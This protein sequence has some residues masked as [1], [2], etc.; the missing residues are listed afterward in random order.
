MIICFSSSYLVIYIQ[1]CTI[2]HLFRGYKFCEWT[3]KESFRKQFSRIYI[4]LQSAIL[5]TIGFPLIFDETN[6]VEAWKS[7]KFVALIKK[8]PSGNVIHNVLQILYLYQCNLH[9]CPPHIF[10]WIFLIHINNVH[11]I[12]FIFC[13]LHENNQIT[14]YYWTTVIFI[15]CNKSFNKMIIIIIV[16]YIQNIVT[17]KV[18][19]WY[20]HTAQYYWVIKYK[21]Y[22]VANMIV[23]A[24]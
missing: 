23:C 10:H 11:I 12:I 3:K 24:I 20:G 5:V 21:L 8:M 18:N 6:F 15:L 22:S 4:S 14:C 9:T 16:S 13:R 17:A 1:L 7:T 19:L 2:G